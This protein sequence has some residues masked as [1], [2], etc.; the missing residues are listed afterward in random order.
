MGGIV[1]PPYRNKVEGEVHRI[2]SRI[3]LMVG[4]PYTTWYKDVHK[5]ELVFEDE[6]GGGSDE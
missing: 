2:M 6:V 1:L 4:T 5:V 3:P